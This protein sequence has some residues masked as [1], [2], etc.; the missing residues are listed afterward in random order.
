LLSVFQPHWGQKGKPHPQDSFFSTKHHHIRSDQLECSCI[1]WKDPSNERK[2]LY[3]VFDR[4]VDSAGTKTST[5]HCLKGTAKVSDNAAMKSSLAAVITHKQATYKDPMI[6]QLAIEDGDDG[7]EKNEEERQE[8]RRNLLMPKNNNRNSTKTWKRISA[9]KIWI[10]CVCWNFV[11]FCYDCRIR[12][13]SRCHYPGSSQCQWRHGPRL[14]SCARKAFSTK[15]PSST[16]AVSLKFIPELRSS[17]CRPSL[18]NCRHRVKVL[19]SSTL[20]LLLRFHVA[21]HFFLILVLCI[22][23]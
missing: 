12:L 3:K 21:S 16:F 8:K 5:G 11:S 2:R 20:R 15:R 1:P 10:T 18:R 6:E 7:D 4:I 19:T 22:F 13:N 9:Y 14:P 17:I 23:T